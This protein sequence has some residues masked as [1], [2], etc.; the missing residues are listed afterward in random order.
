MKTVNEYLQELNCFDYDH[1]LDY[2]NSLEAETVQ[3]EVLNFEVGSCEPAEHKE[4]VSAK[5][6]NDTYDG[7]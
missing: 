6:K 3:A 2:R 5:Y 7:Q 4:M 1:M